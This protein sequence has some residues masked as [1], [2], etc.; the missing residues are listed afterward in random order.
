MPES[1]ISNC[2]YYLNK[3]NLCFSKKLSIIEK[4]VTYKIYYAQKYTHKTH[5]LI[6]IK[7]ITRKKDN[8][9]AREITLNFTI[10]NLLCC[11]LFKCNESGLALSVISGS[12]DVCLS[13]PGFSWFK[14]IYGDLFKE[15][16]EQ[17]HTKHN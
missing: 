1:F 13:F 3:S 10:L 2:S 7:K 5:H 8:G 11:F 6:R 9:L 15:S 4:K 14:N 16:M 12:N 17:N